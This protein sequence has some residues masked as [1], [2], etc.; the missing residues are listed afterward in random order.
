MLFE[1]LFLEKADLQKFQ[2]FRVLKS[3]GA[4]SMTINDISDRL[5]LS[6]QQTYNTFQDLI[7]DIRVLDPQLALDRH[8]LLSQ[9]TFRTSLERYRLFL[10]EQSLVFQFVDYLLQASL[11]TVGDFCE[12]HFVSKSTLLRKS[13]PLKHLMAKY[14][15]RFSYSSMQII[16]DEANIRFFL[17]IVYWIG[18]HGIK[19]P[20]RNFTSGAVQQSFFTD[21]PQNDAIIR[22][23]QTLLLGIIRLRIDHRALMHNNPMITNLTQHNPRFEQL[24]FSKKL[25]PNLTAK[26]R[27]YE[28][29]F[30]FFAQLSLISSAI[31]NK[32][33]MRELR[34]FLEAED[35]ATW[36]FTQSLLNHI[37][38]VYHVKITSTNEPTLVYNIVR[39]LITATILQTSYPKMLDF[40]HEDLSGFKQTK[41]YQTIHSYF[42][43]PI[44]QQS[45]PQLMADRQQTIIHLC[46]LLQPRLHR[47]EDQKVVQIW[48]IAENNDL[49]TTELQRLLEHL[50][51]ARIIQPP[52]KITA[53]D[54]ILSTID[55][56]SPLMQE[57]AT[58]GIPMLHWN[59]EAN[60]SDFFDLYSKIRQLY[61]K[62]M[63]P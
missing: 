22:L 42:E 31:D 43:Q 16:G 32:R 9:H 13:A 49:L 59:L 23:Q 26:N 54:L 41:L 12:R 36:H 37:A 47:F 52:A 3:I 20:F 58:Y 24:T 55:T 44:I 21:N 30:F 15:L 51:I 61:A 40:Y 63:I 10:L 8:D 53:A 35:S 7:R 46:Y 6:Y 48:L 17:F 39:V 56:E 14:N 57:L 50:Q 19:W 1:E 2:M 27:Q 38:T 62:K 60:D 45:Y 28:T 11:P 29:R 18:F 25:F 5:N 34:A 33:R 4:N